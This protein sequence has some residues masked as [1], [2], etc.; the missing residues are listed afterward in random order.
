M[1]NLLVLAASK[2]YGFAIGTLILNIVRVSPET[3][4]EVAI[5]SSDLSARDRDIISEALPAEFLEYDPPIS[6][7]AITRSPY[8]RF[9]TPYVLAKLEAFRLVRNYDTVTW[10]DE[11][12]VVK[13]PLDGLVAQSV[14]GA[15][16]M[17]SSVLA[18]NL[19]SPIPGFDSQIPVPAG[20]TF[21]LS[22]E[23][24]P[25]AD[26]IYHHMVS[27]LERYGRHLYLPE[28][29]VMAMAFERLGVSI[30]NL[31]PDLYAAHPSSA[32]PNA[33]ILHAFGPK[34]FW[35][36]LHCH[37]WNLNYREWVLKGGSQIGNLA[38]QREKKRLLIKFEIRFLRFLRA[39]Q[40]TKAPD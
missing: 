17:H 16:F 12:V 34:K 40:L 20:G 21:S 7:R 13:R 18:Q 29:A 30:D 24:A 31:D 32:G 9:F 3:F 37:D 36:G 28:Q 5:F 1:Q 10:L 38:R 6:R 2:G 39:S 25:Y 15:K 26:E 4:S 19:L 27:Y 35:S 33:R 11:D 8:I 22:R 23:I 14:S